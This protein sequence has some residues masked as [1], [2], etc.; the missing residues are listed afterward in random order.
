M[1]LARRLRATLKIKL[2]P[3]PATLSITPEMP[4]LSRT[5]TRA[6]VSRNAGLPFNM[7][8]GTQSRPCSS[9][10]LPN[11]A[12]AGGRWLRRGRPEC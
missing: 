12:A 2:V 3:R 4:L 8:K 9:P 1:P 6:Y 11:L 7:F 10:A 5:T